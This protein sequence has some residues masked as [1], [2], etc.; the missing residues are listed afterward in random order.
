MARSLPIR[1]ARPSAQLL[2]CDP[3][4]KKRDSL[5]FRSPAALDQVAAERPLAA[6]LAAHVEWDLDANVEAARTDAAAFAAL[7][8]A[9]GPG[10]PD[11]MAG[12]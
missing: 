8:A 7:Y 2:H 1:A 4:G 10:P 5:W 12:P 9:L 6:V 3:R 11:L